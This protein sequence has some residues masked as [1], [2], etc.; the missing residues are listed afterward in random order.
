MV[1]CEQKITITNLELFPINLKQ[2]LD[3]CHIQ[4]RDMA[5]F[6]TLASYHWHISL[7]EKCGIG[8][9]PR[10]VVTFLADH[11]TSLIQ[12]SLLSLMNL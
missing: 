2:P 6:Y 3:H 11:I 1:C 7:G 8:L 5:Q 4:K 9:L 10:Y 12:L